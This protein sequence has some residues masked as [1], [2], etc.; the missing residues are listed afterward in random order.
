MSTPSRSMHHCF[1]PEPPTRCPATANASSAVERFRSAASPACRTSAGQANFCASTADE[2]PSNCSSL[3]RSALQ[4]SRAIASGP[5]PQSSRRS[6]TPSSAS[7]SPM[8]LRHGAEDQ[9]RRH[10]RL[11]V[12]AV[13]TRRALS[14]GRR[15]SGVP[16]GDRGAATKARMSV[17]RRIASPVCNECRWRS[18]YR[19]G[20]SAVRKFRSTR[21]ANVSRDS[22]RIAA[23]SPIASAI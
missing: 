23:I 6:R 7:R 16:R 3:P 4:P 1:H 11:V 2:R 19:D 12:R 17:Y 21:A 20:V 8:R 9:A 10:V 18:R 13:D 14:H 15:G 5:T 22:P